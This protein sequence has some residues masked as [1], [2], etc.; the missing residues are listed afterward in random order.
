MVEILKD[1]VFY[2]ISGG[3]VTLGGG[4]V[5]IWPKFA[6]KLL[7]AC[8]AEG[9]HTAIETCGHGPW[10]NIECLLNYLDLVLFDIKHLD[11]E[12]HNRYT[13]VNNKLILENLKR[14]AQES[15]PVVVRIAVVPG[16]NNDPEN[17]REIAVYVRDQGIASKI[18]LLPYHRLGE[19]KYARLGRS[20]PLQGLE[21]PD[22]EEMEALA[23]VVRSE[24]LVCQVGG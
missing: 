8:K 1:A 16:V 4:E 18:E 6:R 23:A 19:E 12:L 11:P 21:P 9:I 3:G 17:I 13:G 10:S 24:G 14:L 5:T 20:Y 2:R 22:E 7:A 15:V